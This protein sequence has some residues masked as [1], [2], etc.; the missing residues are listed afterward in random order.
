M[1]ASD[2]HSRMLSAGIQSFWGFLDSGL[3]RGEV[4][5]GFFNT[6]LDVYQGR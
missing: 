2:R 5:K 3:G 4:T 1:K 6:L